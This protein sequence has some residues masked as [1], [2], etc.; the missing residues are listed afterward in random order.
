M[1]SR[2]TLAYPIRLFLV[3]LALIATTVGGVACESEPAPTAVSPTVAPSATP[4]PIATKIPTATATLMPTATPMP[5]NTPMPM[6]TPTSTLTPFEELKA[7]AIKLSYDDLFRNN[8]Q[9]IGKKVWLTAKIIQVIEIDSDEFQLRAKITE[10][11][12]FWDDTVFLQYSGPRLLED[13][14]IEFVGSVYGLITYE[15]ISGQEITIPAITFT[16]ASSRRLEAKASIASGTRENPIPVGNVAVF[17]DWDVSVVS[18]DSNATKRIIAE[19]RLNDS[20]DPGHAYIMVRVQGT[21]TGN[22]MGEMSRD[23]KFYVVGDAN[24]LYDDP[25]AVIPDP[26]S[27]Q[28]G[29]LTGGTVEGNI[30]FVVPLSEVNSL[31]LVV[32]DGSL[33]Y[34]DTVVYLSL[35]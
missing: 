3:I 10:N 17:P 22:R 7:E 21:Y 9:H 4:V 23:L 5:T 20:P 13:D 11:E 14:I 30:K 19:N 33:R 1:L 32:A 29:A 6:P 28:P 34:A 12:G 27:D 31:V 24:L 26:L 15:S 8:E 35:E 18:F 2:F 25:R 16:S